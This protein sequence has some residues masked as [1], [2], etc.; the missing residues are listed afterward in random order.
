MG[1]RIESYSLTE[2]HRIAVPGE[3]PPSLFWVL[4]IGDWRRGELDRVWQRFTQ[5]PG[6]CNDF[7]LLLVKG[8]SP[9]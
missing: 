6:E 5:D 3:V 7:G 2:L 1:Y 9:R 8:F 4:P